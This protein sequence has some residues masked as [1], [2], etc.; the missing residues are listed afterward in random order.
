MFRRKFGIKKCPK[1]ESDKY[2]HGCHGVFMPASEEDL[3]GIEIDNNF[4]YGH[5]ADRWKCDDCGYV[6]DD[7]IEKVKK[8]KIIR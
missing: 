3:K 7:D 1:C 4:I 2:G 8:M 6:K 5:T